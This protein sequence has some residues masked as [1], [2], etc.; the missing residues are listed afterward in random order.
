MELM[1][2]LIPSTFALTGIAVLAFIWASR[3][4]QFNN[5][6]RHAL[7]ILDEDNQKSGDIDEHLR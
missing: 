7:D 1:L 5:L 2:W 4:G 6:D 3:H